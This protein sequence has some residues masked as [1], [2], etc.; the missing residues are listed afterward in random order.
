MRISTMALCR[1]RYDGLVGLLEKLVDAPQVVH[2]S[3]R[4][5][6]SAPFSHGKIGLRI[7]LSEMESYSFLLVE[8]KRQSLFQSRNVFRVQLSV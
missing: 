5:K 2:G 7:A 3:F 1:K 6:R 8:Q 4:V